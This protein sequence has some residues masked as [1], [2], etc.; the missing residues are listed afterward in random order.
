MISEPLFEQR[1]MTNGVPNSAEDGL[2]DNRRIF[3]AIREHNPEKARATMRA[4]MKTAEHYWRLAQA[5]SKSNGD[6]QEPRLR[7]ESI[8]F[9]MVERPA[10]QP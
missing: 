8:E 10:R 7:A 4:H 6:K 1:R 2:R 3:R 9:G 5:S